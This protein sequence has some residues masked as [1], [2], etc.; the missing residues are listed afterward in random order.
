[1]TKRIQHPTLGEQTYEEIKKLII[2]GKIKPG[3]RLLYN[4]VVKE[5]G[6]SQTPIKEAFTRLEH[7]GYLVSIKRKGTFVRQ[8]SPKDIAEVFQI[9]EMLE[10]LAVR[11]VCRKAEP[12]AIRR[13]EELNQRFMEA[14]I[15]KDENTCI[16]ADYNFHTALIELSGNAKLVELMTKTNYHLISI[17]QRSE[18]SLEIAGSYSDMHRSI[19]DALKTGDE[20]EAERLMREH[21]RTGMAE[22]GMP[23]E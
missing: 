17:A 16:Q 18:R 12:E 1:M 9:R 2:W 5:L 10:A 7:D 6:V 3:E 15:R 21:I 8:I 20:D 14:A 4:R 22:V 19:I 11:L 23:G 13:L